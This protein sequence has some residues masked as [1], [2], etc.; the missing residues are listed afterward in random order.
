MRMC[1]HMRV[2]AMTLFVGTASGQTNPREP[3]IGYVYPGGG[4]E[5]KIVEVLVGGQY[6]RG[7]TNVHV[8]G[9]GVLASVVEH[10]PP[11][12]NLSGEQRKELRR[13][14]R[15][16][17]QKRLAEATGGGRGRLARGREQPERRRANA[18]KGKETQ[19]EP[20][21]ATVE[22]PPHP[23]LRDIEG[24]S[25]RELAHL[26]HELLGLRKRQPNAQIA[27]SVLIEVSIDEDA[28]PG[29]REIRLQTP[30]GLTNPLRFEVGVLPEV[31]ELEPN[32]PNAAPLPG[33]EDAPLDLPI[34]VNGQIKPG[35]VDRVRFRAQRGQKLVIETQ[36]RH[37]IPYL[38][39][40]VPG[41]FQA[42]LALY[43]DTGNQV[44]FA[45][46]YRFD[47]DPVLFFEVPR[48]GDYE[49]EVRDALYRG[50]EDFV[51][52][53][54]VAEQPFI[55][56]AF[57]LGARTGI[58][59]VAAIDGWNLLRERLTLGTR[60]NAGHIRQTALQQRGERSNAVT[61]AV[62]RLPECREAEPNDTVTGAQRIDVPQ[63]INGRIQQPGDVDVFM[64]LGKANGAI[65][66]EV[67][68]RRLNSPVDS[69]LRLT[70]ASGQILEWND[71][72]EDKEAGL[73]TH[74]ADSYLRARLP[75]DGHYYVQVSD[76]QHHGGEA[77]AYRLRVGPPR[78]DFALRVT[79]SSV[80]VR[81]GR[82]AV[83]RV[84]ALR[85]D[86]FDGAIE[87]GLKEAPPGFALQGARI[88]AGRESV[89]MTLTAPPGP[90]DAPVALQ[91]E[92]RAL[93]H[94][95][96]VR[97]SAV[98]AEDMMQAFAY[99]HLTP[100]QEFLVAVI[101]R[102]PAPPVAVVGA[103]PVRIRAGGAAAV[104]IRT[105]RRLKV[106]EVTLALSEPPAGLTIGALRAAPGGLAFEVKADRQ[107]APTGFADNLI[108]EAFLDVAAGK[109][110]G[111]KAK[112]KRRVPLGVLPA[113]PFEIVK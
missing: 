85:K 10:Y 20:K 13:R 7:V 40:A 89:R 64:F 104:R 113:I 51:Y 78:P 50:R 45:D 43:D 49:L 26:R 83:L 105:P 100:S 59:T 53:V 109:Q 65:V 67:F 106:D 62:D 96:T 86:G 71:D 108:V 17:W 33:G 77:Y 24:K 27:E 66:A 18:S 69:L 30:R 97:R 88:P 6:L 76:A 82:A 23:L 19:D 35:D 112:K 38:A 92:G 11:L 25:L 91:M 44:A 37:L 90:V 107:A 99:R 81:A 47:P 46:D 111:N 4:Q 29:E 21:R 32:E 79:P 48:T 36:A 98:P 80:N 94:G 93:I 15:A 39:D 34:L 31:C 3:H 95:R 110:E 103:T 84:H 5:G 58:R 28:A 14:L 54:A 1:R 72:H 12:K 60:P 56:Q 2:A 9:K 87:L 61:Y 22:L 102:R 63:I 41:W 8:S 70:D 42:T 73:C 16:A 75:R 52:R 74:H 101:G 55:T 68:G 57:P